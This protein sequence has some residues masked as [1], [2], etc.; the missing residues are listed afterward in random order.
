LKGTTAM[1]KKFKNSKKVKNNNK[2]TKQEFKK[3]VAG[4]TPDELSQVYDWLSNQQQ[5]P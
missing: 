3:L 4:L 5:T 1:I 2:M